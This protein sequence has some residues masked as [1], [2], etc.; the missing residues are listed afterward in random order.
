[1]ISCMH[2]MEYYG[3]LFWKFRTASPKCTTRVHFL[4]LNVNQTTII[5]A[6]S[7][8]FPSLTPVMYPLGLYSHF[9]YVFTCYTHLFSVQTSLCVWASWVLHYHRFSSFIFTTPGAFTYSSHM[10]ITITFSS[11]PTISVGQGAG[12]NTMCIVKTWRYP[13]QHQT[14]CWDAP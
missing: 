5:F 7:Y 11:V 9:D 1:M 6:I 2:N 10:E 12:A 13:W 14:L 3:I 8:L 4:I